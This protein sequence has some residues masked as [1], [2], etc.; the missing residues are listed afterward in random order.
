MVNEKIVRGYS[1]CSRAIPLKHQETSTVST[2][3]FRPKDRIWSFKFKVYSTGTSLSFGGELRNLLRSLVNSHGNGKCTAWRWYDSYVLFT[4]W[5]SS[6]LCCFRGGYGHCQSFSIFVV[7]ETSRVLLGISSQQSSE[8]LRRTQQFAHSNCA[9]KIQLPPC[10]LWLRM[11]FW[12]WK[13]KAFPMMEPFTSAS[14]TGRAQVKLED[15]SGS[16]SLQDWILW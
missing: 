9:A 3:F 10:G 2:G 11:W 5:F 13:I 1:Q 6:L 4:W 16:M 15:V 7:F 8:K 14:R 12:N